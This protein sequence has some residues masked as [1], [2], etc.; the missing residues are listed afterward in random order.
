MFL[1][2]KTKNKFQQK[3]DSGAKLSSVKRLLLL[4]MIQN[5]PEKYENVAEILS[6][7]KL[8]GLNFSVSAD[9]KMCMY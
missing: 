8:E 4:A 1:Y 2:I 9:I 6:Q 7:L 3:T 5:V